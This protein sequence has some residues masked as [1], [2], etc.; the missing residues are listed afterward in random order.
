MTSI[1]ISPVQTLTSLSNAIFRAASCA[2]AQLYHLLYR[3]V[4]LLD[5]EQRVV[6]HLLQQ[7]LT[8]SGHFRH[9]AKLRFVLDVKPPELL[10]KF[11]GQRR[12][13]P[14]NLLEGGQ[15]ALCFCVID[16]VRLHVGLSHRI[17]NQ[18]AFLRRYRT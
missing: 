10:G 8:I 1:N 7:A 16:T 15:S 14:G 3:P 4:S 9:H 18:L 11:A 17:R 12:L 2:V 13:D 6:G 5:H